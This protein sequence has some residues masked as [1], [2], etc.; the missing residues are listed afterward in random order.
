MTE[1][2]IGL[3]RGRAARRCRFMKRGDAIAW[4]ALGLAFVTAVGHAEIKVGA[5][6][7]VFRGVEFATGSADAAEPRRQE[8]RVVRIDLR[9]PGV[10]LFATPSNGDA[11]LETTSE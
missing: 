3:R 4:I 11:P 5:W 10:E 7:P 9:T 6:T 1:A 8:V 2:P